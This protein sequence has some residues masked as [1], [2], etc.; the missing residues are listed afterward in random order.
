MRT[1]LHCKAGIPTEKHSSKRMYCTKQCRMAAYARKSLTPVGGKMASGTTGAIGE[2][3]VAGYLMDLTFP[4]FRALS[5]NCPFDI[6]ALYGPA[7]IGIEVRT[8]WRNA[9]TKNV[10][11]A[12]YHSGADLFAVRIRREIDPLL[13]PITDAGKSFIEEV[14][15]RFSLWN[16]QTQH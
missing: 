9:V 16:S 13:I 7:L 3:M 5:P 4:V 12:N 1:C 2:L 14:S 8:G 6:V 10:S 11:Y 15:R